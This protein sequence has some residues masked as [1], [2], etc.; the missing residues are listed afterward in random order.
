L[1]KYIINDPAAAYLPGLLLVPDEK[2]RE[3]ALEQ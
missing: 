1:E 3:A 2:L